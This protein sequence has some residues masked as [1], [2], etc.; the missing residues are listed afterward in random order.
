MKSNIPPAPFGRKVSDPL[1]K[2][3]QFPSASRHT[4]SILRIGNA[5]DAGPGQKMCDRATVQRSETSKVW[6]R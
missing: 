2:L 1:R 4:T 3:D 6:V 5:V